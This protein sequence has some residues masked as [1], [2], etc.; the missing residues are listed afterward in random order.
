MIKF[1]GGQNK[2]SY[3]TKMVKIR[4][5]THEKL[6]LRLLSL[7]VFYN[8]YLIQEKRIKY[9]ELE[10]ELYNTERVHGFSYNTRVKELVNQK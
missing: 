7:D 3:P 2:D 8:E 10:S 5:F 1:T 6:S 9:F 4:S